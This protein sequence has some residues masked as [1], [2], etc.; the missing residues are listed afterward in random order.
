[1][2]A[3]TVSRY[4]APPTLTEVPEPRPGPRE[5]LIRV[6]VAGVNPMDRQIADGALEST[7]PA[8]FPLVLGAD[9][10]G[11]VEALGEGASRFSPGDELFGHLM[12]APIGSAGTYAEHVAVSED[13]PLARIPRGLDWAVAAS[14]PTTGVTALQIVASLGQLVGKTALIVGAAGGVGSFA[15]Q[16]AVQAGARVIAV[17]R[18]DATERLHAYGAAE[19]VDSASI[20]VADIVHQT[21]PAGID[22]LVDLVSS[23]DAFATLAELVQPGG[24]A[25]TTKY[26]ADTEALASRGASGINFSLEMTSEALEQFGDLVAGG[27]IEIPPVTT[28]TLEE[29]PALNA[30]TRV[31]GK[32]VI[33]V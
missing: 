18:A 30:T 11:V 19:T 22:V 2:R 9:L 32:T 17:D 16:L 13:A 4:G 23:A 14:L 15:T 24:T 33:T 31:S 8:H 10:A 26:V 27:R 3:I 12:I 29:V 21:H 5:L 28:I 1:M 20:S 6:Q 7:M 25:L